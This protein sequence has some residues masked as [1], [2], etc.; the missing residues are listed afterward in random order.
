LSARYS[1]SAVQGP[2]K[3]CE[4]TVIC[5]SPISFP[6]SRF[7]GAMAIDRTS[8]PVPSAAFPAG[9]FPHPQK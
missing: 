2:Q 5:R 8:A 3:G 7:P 9:A 1:D 4:Y 6:L